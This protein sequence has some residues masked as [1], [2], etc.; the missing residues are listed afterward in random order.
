MTAC[1]WLSRAEREVDLQPLVTRW[2]EELESS[3]QEADQVLLA[4]GEYF[5]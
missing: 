3:L 4:L 2:R 1:S 5:G